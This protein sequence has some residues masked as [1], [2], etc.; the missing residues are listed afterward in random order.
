MESCSDEFGVHRCPLLCL[1]RQV[2]KGTI[3]LFHCWYFLYKNNMATNL[4]M[5]TSCYGSRRFVA[6]DC[7]TQ[8]S[9]QAD[10]AARQWLLIAASHVDL[11]CE[12][13]HER[14]CSSGFTC[15]KNAL[16][17]R[18]WPMCLN[19]KLHLCR[20]L[21]TQYTVKL[22]DVLEYVCAGL[23]QYVLMVKVYFRY[24]SGTLYLLWRVFIIHL[25]NFIKSAWCY[26]SSKLS[27]A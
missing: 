23:W 1:Q 7:W 8:T 22:C 25:L 5:F 2:T 14:I 27:A 21:F 9:W 11:L 15:L 3:G 6:C 10:N 19:V 12:K 16:F 13:K 17:V 18:L 4:Q 26:I 24:L 20:L